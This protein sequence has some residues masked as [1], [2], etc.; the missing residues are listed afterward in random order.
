MDINVPRRLGSFAEGGYCQASS[1]S[2]GELLWVHAAQAFLCIKC[3]YSRLSNPQ[4]VQKA[5]QGSVDLDRL[6]QALGENHARAVRLRR[7]AV[8]QLR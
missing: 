6:E 4:V 5:V 3:W 8:G 1:V 7:K 2:C